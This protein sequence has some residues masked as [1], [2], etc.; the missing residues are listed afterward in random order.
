MIDKIQWLGHGTFLIKGPPL[1]Y[2]N[3][4]RVTRG[5]FHADV[6]LISHTN[7]DYCSIADIEKLCGP[8][9]RII[10]NSAVQAQITDTEIIRPW[11]SI[12]ID[13]TSIKAIPAYSLNSALHPKDTGAIGFLI[14]IEFYDIYYAGNTELIPELDLIRPDIALLPINGEGTM[15]VDDAVEAV[16]QLRPRWTV[17]FQ[18]GAGSNKVTKLDAMSFKERVGDRSKVIIQ[19]PI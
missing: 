13:R 17:P 15:T 19:E 18:W 1:I 4:W 16:E 7:Y 6:I 9:T 8:H 14:S 3:P 11:Q 12:S 10:G 5:T 2:I